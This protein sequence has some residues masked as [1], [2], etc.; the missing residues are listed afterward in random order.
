MDS[1]IKPM[2]CGRCKKPQWKCRS[3]GCKVCDHFCNF[4]KKDGTA[5]CGRCIRHTRFNFKFTNTKEKTNV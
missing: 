1:I 3:C 2:K 4:K 5:S